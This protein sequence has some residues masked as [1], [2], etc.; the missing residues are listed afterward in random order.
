V[1]EARPLRVALSARPDQEATETQAFETR[2][3]QEVMEPLRRQ[4]AL[5]GARLNI[6]AGQLL[7][8]LLD[9]GGSILEVVGL[10][11]G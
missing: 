7:G 4:V 8:A 10:R 1:T 9:T 6:R 11:S 5:E 2:R 3:Q